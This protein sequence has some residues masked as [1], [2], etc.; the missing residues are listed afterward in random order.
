MDSRMIPRRMP[1]S[2]PG[3]P[4]HLRVARVRRAQHRR[5]RHG[6]E[7]IA[8]IVIAR[9]R[10]LQGVEDFGAVGDRAAEDA[11]AIA[12]DVRPDGA[13]VEAEQRLVR[14][15]E[16][17]GIVI[18]RSAAGRPRFLAEAGHHQIGAD[19][20]PR[21]RTRAERGRARRVVG[22]GGVA[23]PGAAL[24]AQRRRQ[25]LLGRVASTRIAGPAVVFRVD[26][27]GEDDRALVPELFDQHVIARREIDVVARVT[28]A[29][30]A[31]VLR[32]ERI[33]ERE[34]DAIHRHLLEVG[35]ASIR[36]IEL[37]RAL[38]RVGQPAKL[39]AHGGRAGGQRPLGHMPVEIAPA[40]D[41][42][43]AADVEGGERIHLPGMRDADDHPELLLHGRIG[44]RRLHAAVF[45][46]RPR[47][48]VEIGQDRGGLD[49]VRREAQRRL[50]AHGARRF[51]DRGA[52][53][54]D[55][56]AGDPVIRAHA[57]DI[58]LH[59]RDAGGLPRL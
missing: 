21:P 57:V 28:P 38:Q 4:G 18:G 46:G 37:G 48:L 40:G 26:G 2:A 59:D 51:G 33:L 7:G 54:G 1:T 42:T 5:A 9:D 30:G 39:L 12:V 14:Q 6:R 20:H 44:G 43:L 15:D 17:H 41:G 11:A 19:R 27:L 34:D 22:V 29:G 13:A 16:R 50:R 53:C 47:V 56:R 3:C 35:M 55:E 49:G 8:R 23:A 31:H 24:I 25:H 36:R 32:V 52:V 45:E 10:V 58:V